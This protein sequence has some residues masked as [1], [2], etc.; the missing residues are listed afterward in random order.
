MDNNNNAF[1]ASEARL[2]SEEKQKSILDK[3]I[4]R[5][6]IAAENGATGID[7]WL[8]MNNETKDKEAVAQLSNDLKEL[9]YYT[10]WRY[11][12]GANDHQISIKW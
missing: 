11:S 5:I 1:N 10:S 3:V 12:T 2:I 6:K 9:G 4:K 8:D 7:T